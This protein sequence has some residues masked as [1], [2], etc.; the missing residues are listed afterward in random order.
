MTTLE[1]VLLVCALAASVALQPWRMLRSSGALP[2]LATPL[3]A[4]LVMLPWLWAWPVGAALPMPLQWSGAALAV[5]MLGWPL[6][7]PALALAG[8]STTLT[9]GASIEDAISATVWSG[10]LPATIVLLLGHVVRRAFGAHPLAYIVGR[11]Y[12]VPLAAVFCGVVASAWAGGGVA[13]ADDTTPFVVA[14][15]MAMGEAAWTCAVASLLVAWQPGW[16]A[17]W[18]DERYLSPRKSPPRRA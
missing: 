14:F 18:S 7:I 1:A 2:P 10:V 15:L 16:L 4:S 5:L 9:A 3:L 13:G 8:A 6:A 11:A 17:T 12:A